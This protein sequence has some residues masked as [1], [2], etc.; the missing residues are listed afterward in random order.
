MDISQAFDAYKAGDKT[1]AAELCQQIIDTQPNSDAYHILGVIQ[2]DQHDWPAAARSLQAASQLNPENHEIWFNLALSYR[3]QKNWSSV[4]DATFEC[5]TRE[6]SMLKAWICRTE[7]FCHLGAWQQAELCW[8]CISQLNPQDPESLDIIGVK[9]LEAQQ[10][11]LAEKIWNDIIAWF[12]SHAAS[13]INRSV[14]YY[15]TGRF[16]Q[17]IGDCHSAQVI[18]PQLGWQNMGSAYQAI[19]E[20]QLGLACYDK[21]LS[22]DPENYETLSNRCVILN[23]LG[24][25]D[26]AVASA[27]RSIEIRPTH[28]AAYNNRGTVYVVQNKIELAERDF[29]RVLH[30]EHNNRDARFNLGICKF[31]QDKWIAGW[32][33]WENRLVLHKPNRQDLFNTNIPIYDGSQEL[34]GKTILVQH[35]QGFGDTIQFIRYT[36]WL[37]DQGAQV[38]VIVPPPLIPLLQTVPWPLTVKT[39]VDLQE[40]NFDYQCAMMSLPLAQGSQFQHQPCTQPYLVADKTR[41]AQ[42]QTQ[43]PDRYRTKIALAWGGNPKHSNNLIR[44]IPLKKLQPLLRLPCDFIC[45][46]NNPLTAEERRFVDSTENLW[47]PQEPFQ[48]FQDTAALVNQCDFTISV[49]TS[50]LHVAGALSK[51]TYAMLPFAACWRW[52]SYE[53]KTTPWYDTVSVHRQAQSADWDSVVQA[54]CWQLLNNL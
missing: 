22:F 31:K 49:D 6:N 41:Q 19:N 34:S 15:N 4:V 32:D 30:L 50:V 47:I 27:T 35:E 33:Y 43:L 36:K 1:L 20:F 24:R 54:V 13:Y 39:A 40:Y 51:P 45:V 48:D 29:E 28:Y 38:V 14:L 53:T 3:A 9:V 44:N 26:E 2:N 42:W 11:T 5:L 52:G 18:N 17:C 16:N 12:P 7:A 23:K 46:Q 21:A 37:H 8:D 10:W 25:N